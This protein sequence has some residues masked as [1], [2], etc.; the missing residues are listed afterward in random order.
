LTGDQFKWVGIAGILLFLGSALQQAGMVYTTAGNAG[1]ITSLYVVLIPILLSLFWKERPHWLT[2]IAACVSVVGAYLLSVGGGL[3]LRFGDI[4]EMIGALF[5]AF[6]VI[7][8]GKYAS[9]YDPVT[10][11]VGQLFVSGLLNLSLGA[12]IERP[13][14]LSQ[15]LILAIVYTAVLSLGLSYSLQVWAQRHTPPADAALILSLESVFAVVCGIFLLGERMATAQFGG[16]VLI[17]GAVVFYKIK[18]THLGQKIIIEKEPT[19]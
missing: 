2:G 16:C 19:A 9:K 11:T 5:W 10:F 17:F 7:V 6:H 4:F 12:V 1:F 18:G 3:V 8:L 13:P 14:L 15:G